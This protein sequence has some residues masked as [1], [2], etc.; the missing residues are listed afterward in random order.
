[1]EPD[2]GHWDNKAK[3]VKEKSKHYPMPHDPHAVDHF[4]G[5]PVHQD[6]SHYDQGYDRR[7]EKLERKEEKRQMKEER[8]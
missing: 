4:G 2:Y 7:A 1:M 3:G 5:H 8:Q 6:Y